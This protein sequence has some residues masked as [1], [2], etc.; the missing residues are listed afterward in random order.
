ML[1]RLFRII[2]SLAIFVS[3][4]AVRQTQG[5]ASESP[6]AGLTLLISDL[7]QVRFRLETPEYEI[8]TSEAAVPETVSLQVPGMS[9]DVTPG[10]PRLPRLSR[11]VAIPAGVD[12]QMT[13][14]TF[15]PPVL[16]GKFNLALAG[17]PQAL[18]DEWEPGIYQEDLPAF[19]TSLLDF[20]G[21]YPVQPVQLGEEAWMR[22]QRMLRVDLFP[23][24]YELSSGRLRWHTALEVVIS[25]EPRTADNAWSVSSEPEPEGPLDWLAEN[26][27]INPDSARQ[28]R[29]QPSGIV[30]EL[31]L[32]SAAVA[33]DYDETRYKI[34]VLEDGLYQVTG[35]D[36]SAAGLDLSQVNPLDFRLTNQGAPVAIQVQDADGNDGEGDGI[37][38]LTDRVVFYGE[39]FRGDRMAERYASEDD[40][41]PIM[42][43]GWQPQMT[44]EMFEKYTAENVYWLDVDGPAGLRIGEISGIP[45][46]N[47]PQPLLFTDT[48]HFEEDNR[49]Y[50]LHRSD[51]DTW[52]WERISLST[53]SSVVTSTYTLDLPG[54]AS[55]INPA[56]LLGELFSATE[57]SSVDPDHH[58]QLF[59]NDH[60]TPILESLWDGSGRYSFEVEID[61]QLLNAGSNQLSLVASLASNTTAA[62]FDIDWF[63]LS[64]ARNFHAENDQ[65]FFRFNEAG[66]IWQ[67]EIDGFTSDQIRVLDI[68]NPLETAFILGWT[69]YV[70]AAGTYQVKFQAQHPQEASYLVSGSALKTPLVSSYTFKNLHQ[71]SLGADYLL[72]AHAQFIQAAQVLADYRA[73]QG[74]RS[75]VI[76]LEDI[77]NEFNDGI[78]HSLAIKSFLAYSMANWVAPAPSYVLLIGSGHWNF[79]GR[80][81]PTNNYSDASIYMPPHLVWV[82]PWQGEVDS[83]SDLAAVIGADTL[84]DLAIGRIPV[85]TPDELL[86][87]IDKIMS[88]EKSP[89]QAWQNRL[90]FVADNQPDLAGDFMD[91]SELVINSSIPDHQHA[92]KIYLNDY[93]SEVD[94]KF[95]T[96]E[97]TKVCPQVNQA[98]VD[99]LNI[100]GAHFLNYIG[101]AS[102]NYWANEWLLVTSSL[103]DRMDDLAY[104]DLASMTNSNQPPILLSMTCLDGYW[105]YPSL[106]RPSLAV[107]LLRKPGGGVAAAY[108]P[109]GLGVAQGHDIL[110]RAFFDA[111]Y[112]QGI[113][114]L[115]SAVASSKVALYATWQN[116]DL[117][118][119]YTIFGDPAMRLLTTLAP[120]RAEQSGQVG[121]TLEY[122]LQL[123]NVSEV[124]DTFTVT[125]ANHDSAVII[126]QTQFLLQP[127]EAANI[128]IDVLLPLDSGTV[129]RLREEVQVFSQFNGRVV[130]SATL[131]S[132]LT[133]S[134]VYIPVLP[135]R[136]IP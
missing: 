45:T 69:E 4:L 26:L 42:P 60:P 87:V 22:G 88:Y 43:T 51:E 79:F 46:G 56:V 124:V 90:A 82:D 67:Y 123:S 72:I 131:V 127:G 8:L 102:I 97:D 64:Y 71:T 132:T 125:L 27:V 121:E 99:T 136:F 74:L 44:A 19:E 107:N 86:A 92:E 15:D 28:W 73:D 95:C 112:E 1:A 53:A 78:Y 103:P 80:P 105:I 119:T 104:N 115:G 76:D 41:W 135:N 130:A 36:L 114:E 55:S 63:E 101:H 5:V 85:D 94:D 120:V 32:A 68:S 70:E 30:E 100:D 59:I 21:F 91:L 62:Q 38:A 2:F 29:S 49:W 7:H 98:I 6:Q 34:I 25:F 109:T 96:P 20:E 118:H 108:S 48:Q 14:H 3:S 134:R 23:F 58:I 61:P 24:Q 117:V 50:T 31:S 10:K 133:G 54:L 111:I 81:G 110:N 57:N 13:F 66:V 9:N 122:T 37:F 84:P 116:L 83:S 12:V 126:P 106:E 129:T 47:P 39:R 113:Q 40:D 33:E 128:L 11:L 89:G 93:L 18:E 52:F 75:L 16:P 77:I 35:A 17:G 65:L